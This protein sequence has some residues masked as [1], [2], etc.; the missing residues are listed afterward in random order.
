VF[1]FT[2]RTIFL[3]IIS[4]ISGRGPIKVISDASQTFAK[5]AFSKEPVAGMN[6]VNVGDLG[7][8]D[9]VRNIQIAFAAAG[10]HTP[11]RRQIERATNFDPPRNTRRP[12][13]FPI[14]YTHKSPAGQF[15][16]G[17]LPEFY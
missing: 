16:R 2:P 9:D 4:I 12:L 7:S 5:L 1:H 15:P 14:P 11:L 3:T 13:K 17:W 10:G 6:G 8:A